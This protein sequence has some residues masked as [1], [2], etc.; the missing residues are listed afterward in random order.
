MAEK[1]LEVDA[2]NQ[3]IAELNQQVSSLQDKL[4]QNDSQALRDVQNTRQKS[5]KAVSETE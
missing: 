3:K 2:A 1:Q 5:D 4:N